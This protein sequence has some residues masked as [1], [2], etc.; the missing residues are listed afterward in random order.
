MGVVNVTE[1]NGQLGGTITTNDR[2]IGMV[3]TGATEG[4]YTAG[5]PILVTSMEDVAT[6]GITGVG[7]AFAN[8]H[9]QEFYNEAPVGSQLYLMLVPTTLSIANIC[10]GTNAN[11]AKKLLDF[12]GGKIKVLICTTDDKAIAAVPIVVTVT[13]GLNALVY[14]AAANMKIMEATYRAAQKPFRGIVGGSSF[15]GTASALTDE[16]SGTSNN[17]CAILIGDTQIWDATNTSACV[18]ILGG[19]IANNPVM[20]KISRVKDGPL[21]PA[22]IYLGGVNTI[23]NSGG[24]PGVIAGKNYITFITYPTRTGYFFSGDPMCTVSTDDYSFLARC[25][26]IDKAHVIAY[27][28]FLDE[29]DDNIPTIAGGL[30]APGFITWLEQQIINNINTN[31]TANGEISGVDCFI[32]PTQVVTNT[33]TLNVVLK[34]SPEAYLSDINVALG[35]EL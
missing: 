29:V 11:G 7:N 20:V 19:R 3:L 21:T 32:D 15:N 22:E 27:D 17:K 13:N 16:S 30:P 8:R 23:E 35:F 10:D 18:G 9:L 26:V 2:V 14:T 4:L 12:A 5:T 28:T 34:V 33:N 1:A 24:A 6:A 31:M 25:R